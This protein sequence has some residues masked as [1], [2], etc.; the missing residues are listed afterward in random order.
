MDPDKWWTY[1]VWMKQVVMTSFL[2]SIGIRYSLEDNN[3][4]SKQEHTTNSRWKDANEPNTR[5]VYGDF[6]K[7]PLVALNPWEPTKNTLIELIR[8][9][10][11]IIGHL[12]EVKP[13][14]S[15]EELVQIIWYSLAAAF[16]LPK[17][18]LLLI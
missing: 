5:N 17:T 14:I 4:I 12:L 13:E 9:P 18:Q 11:S 1:L 8:V 15:N 16:N 10:E 3:I 7:K 2:H 6:I